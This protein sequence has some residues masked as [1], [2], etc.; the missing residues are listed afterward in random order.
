ANPCAARSNPC[1]AKANP[2]AAKANPCAA[3][4]N[5]CAAN[6]C[7]ANPCGPCGPCGAAAAVEITDAEAVAAYDC[8]LKEIKAAYAKSSDPV[9]KTYLSW[10]Q[11][12]KHAYQ[13][14]THGARYVQNFANAKAQAYGRYEK[15]GKL[16][17]GAQ[18]AKNSFSVAPD[19]SVSVGP[20]FIMEKMP[21]GFYAASGDWKYTMVMPDGSTFGQTKGAN[22]ANMEFCVACHAAAADNDH[23]M[24]L[25]E[26]YRAAG[27]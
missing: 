12:S 11:Y 26:E 10:K 8:V 9:A 24:F 25:P 21:A 1:A 15:S 20:V 5:P 13:S 16:P 6:P 3:K 14:A 17:P 19:G 2:C 27:R 23:L 4:A 18:L 22:A 7:A